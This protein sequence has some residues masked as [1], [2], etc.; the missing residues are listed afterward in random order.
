MTWRGRRVSASDRGDELNSPIL[1]GK[2]V[3]VCRMVLDQTSFFGR[4]AIEVIPGELSRRGVSKALVVTDRVLVADGVAGKVTGQLDAAGFVYEDCEAVMPN[5]SIE[6]V[7]AGVKAFA[8]LHNRGCS[9]GWRV[10]RG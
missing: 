4:R 1:T 8:A 10:G 7:Q 3:I 2:L 5:S 9:E 6:A